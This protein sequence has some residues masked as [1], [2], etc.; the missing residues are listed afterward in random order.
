MWCA[1]LLR[2][3]AAALRLWAAVSRLGGGSLGCSC[4]S[5]TVGLQSAWLSD[6]LSHCLFSSSSPSPS[7]PFSVS[8]FAAAAAA[9][10]DAPLAMASVAFVREAASEISKPK[11]GSGV[12]DSSSLVVGLS[13]SVPMAVAVAD[14]RRVVIGVPEGGGEG[15][16]D[17]D[18]ARW[19]EEMGEG[20]MGGVLGEVVVDIFSFRSSPGLLKGCWRFGD[21]IW[22]FGG[23]WMVRV[24]WGIRLRT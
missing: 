6:S 3:R 24:R 13:A 14:F 4:W 18:E 7:S 17:G 11:K 5:S 9:C 16:G 19:R 15:D 12:G 2:F 21:E 10:P 22:I 23:G 20:R 8:P 1:T